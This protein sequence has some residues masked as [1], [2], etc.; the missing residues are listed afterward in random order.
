[1]LENYSKSL[2]LKLAPIDAYLDEDE[3]K[4]E[5]EKIKLGRKTGS[6]R[7]YRIYFTFITKAYNVCISQGTSLRKWFVPKL[8]NCAFRT[9]YL[10]LIR[11]NIARDFLITAGLKQIPYFQLHKLFEYYNYLNYNSYMIPFGNLSGFSLYC[12]IYDTNILLKARHLQ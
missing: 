6:S 8:Y 1:M 3:L 2:I 12:Q 5:M 4:K 10:E 7:I 9:I 11:L